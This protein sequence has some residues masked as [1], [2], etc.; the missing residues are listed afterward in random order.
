MTEHTSFVNPVADTSGPLDR[1]RTATR[2]LHEELDLQLP[3]AR[4][5][6]GRNDYLNHLRTLQPWLA[7][8]TP[9]LS[10]TG[11]G[12]G[13]AALAAR[14]L[15]Q[16][17]EPVPAPW[18]LQPHRHAGVP[19]FDWGV[20]YVAEGSQLG[21]QVLYRRLAAALAPLQAD[22]LRGRGDA[23]GAHWRDFLQALR[24]ALTT[25]PTTDAAC[26]GAV[27]AFTTLIDNYKKQGLMA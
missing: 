27:W 21:G 5:G 7:A 10:R 8:V 17:G 18:D 14:D 3:L 11:W 24:G 6:A 4:P 12:E 23:T 20:A 22:Y 2:A 9:L 19:G 15:A 13:L 25:P 26:D 16:A 1:L